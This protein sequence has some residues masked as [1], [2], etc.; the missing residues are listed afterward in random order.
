MRG[1]CGHSIRARARSADQASVADA[2][3]A[4][5][6]QRRAQAFQFVLQRSDVGVADGASQ[7]VGGVGGGR[8]VQRKQVLHHHL[9]LLLGGASGAD[10]GFL[11][12]QR[13]V[14]VDGQ[15]TV[16]QCAQR[17]APRL[18][19]RAAEGPRVRPFATASARF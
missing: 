5:H 2:R 18:P 10:H 13:G 19:P 8:A 17:C 16:G 7:R 14:L 15:R 4:A 1:E 9:H 6:A 11:D 3:L 12:L